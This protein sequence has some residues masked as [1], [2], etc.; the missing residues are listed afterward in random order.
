[1][2]LV[3]SQLTELFVAWQLG[4]PAWLLLCWGVQGR[5]RCWGSGHEPGSGKVHQEG[6]SQRGGEGQG[7]G[8]QPCQG[9]GQVQGRVQHW[10]QPR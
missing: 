8:L 3:S 4:L 6:L 2:L 5:M 7:L 1:M 10:R 9:Q